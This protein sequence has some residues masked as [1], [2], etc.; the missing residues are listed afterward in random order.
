MLRERER[1]DHDRG[2]PKARRPPFR[3]MTAAGR[4]DA[5]ELRVGRGVVDHELVRELGDRDDEDQVRRR[6]RTMSA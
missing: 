5:V 1:G 4:D 2:R 6:A 3:E